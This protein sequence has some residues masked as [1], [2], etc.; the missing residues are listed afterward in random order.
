VSSRCN[1]DNHWLHKL[2]FDVVI[3]FK[4]TYKLACHNYYM[5]DSF[6]SQ[7][8]LHQ[9]KYKTRLESNDKGWLWSQMLQTSDGT[10]AFEQKCILGMLVKRFGFVFSHIMFTPF[11][12][13]CRVRYFQQLWLSMEH[14]EHQYWCSTLKW[15]LPPFWARMKPKTALSKLQLALIRNWTQLS[16]LKPNNPVISGS[17]TRQSKICVWVNG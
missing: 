2:R 12:W 5:L 11:Q 8:T 17:I 13:S 14:H 10:M 1:L 16:N 6:M 15:V 7:L 4:R 3:I 9:A